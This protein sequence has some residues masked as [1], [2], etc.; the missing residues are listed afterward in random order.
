MFGTTPYMRN[1]FDDR[2]DREGPFDGTLG[3]ALGV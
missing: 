1:E 2:L 3:P